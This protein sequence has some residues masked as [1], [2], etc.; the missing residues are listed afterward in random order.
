[1]I[2]KPKNLLNINNLKVE[3]LLVD[4]IEKVKIG[5]CLDI[6]ISTD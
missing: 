3:S 5:N 4:R 1:M 6:M 2:Y